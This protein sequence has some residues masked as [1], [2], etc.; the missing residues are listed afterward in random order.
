MKQ[1]TI[2]IA[3]LISKLFEAKLNRFSPKSTLVDRRIQST[4]VLC[5]I[6]LLLGTTLNGQGFV[7][8]WETS[9]AN[10]T[11]TIPTN[12]NESNYLYTVNWGDASTDNTSYTADASHQ[13]SSPGVYTVE[14]TGVFPAV[15]FNNNADKDKILTI[16]QWGNINWTTMERAFYGC[17]KVVSNATDA[18]NLTGVTNTSWMFLNATIFDG[19][20][21]GWDV[22]SV[23]DMSWM[24]NNAKAFNGDIS[25]WDVSSVTT[26]FLMLGGASSFNQDIGAWDV[27]NVID[28]TS[29]LFGTTS[30]NQ[31]ISAWDVSNVTSMYYLFRGA[32]VFN[33]DISS[34]DVSNVTNMNSMFFGAVEF[35]QDLSSWNVGQVEIMTDMF[36]NAFVFDQDLGGWDVTSVTDMARMLD[37]SGISQ[38]NYDATLIG[39]AS[40]TAL[41][42]AVSLGADGLIY[43]EAIT[44]R[45]TLTN[46]KG[47]VITG[48]EECL[49]EGFISTWQTT[50][51]NESITIPINAAYAN[52]AYTVDWGDGNLDNTVYTTDATHTYTNA[53][54]Y[55]V[56]ITGAFPAIQ[57][58][59]SGDRTKIVAIE[60]WG[61]T[62][63]ES[64]ENAFYG[65]SNLVLNATDVP[66][67]TN[68][69][70][71]TN[72]FNGATNFNGDLNDWDVSNVTSMV[73]TFQDA[74]SFNGN[75]SDWDVSSTVLML[76]TFNGASTFNQDLSGWDISNVVR[77]ENMF[78][79]ATVFNADLSGWDTS[80]IFDMSGMFTNAAAFDQDV[81]GWDV[82]SVT[83]MSQLFAGATVFNQD[84]GGWNVSAVTNM[85]SLFTSALA[86]NQD[87]GNWDVAAVTNMNGM[88]WNT[89]FNQDLSA[90]DVSSVTLMSQMFG[91]AT[92]FNQNL[93]AWDISSVNNMTTMLD[94][95]ALSTA[96]YDA[97][98][99][100]WAN[101]SGLQS[102]V[103]LGAN[104]LTYCTS[105][106]D[107]TDLISNLGWTI[108][109]DASANCSMISVLDFEQ[110]E[111][112]DG[113]SSALSYGATP[114]GVAVE[115]AFTIQNSG[116]TTLTISEVA[117]DGEGFSL[118]SE[119][120]TIV[121]GQSTSVFTITMVSE[122]EG[123]YEASVTVTSDNA[124]IPAYDF[125]ISGEV[126][127]VLGAE[128]LAEV[129]VYPNPASDF[130]HLSSD[131]MEKI[132][133]VSIR[134]VSGKE[135]FS[136]KNLTRRE[137]I[138]IPLKDFKPG[139]YYLL[140]QSKGKTNEYPFIKE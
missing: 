1:L 24:F 118:S 41:Q 22:S 85:N 15:Y 34:W 68:V 67:L 44:A 3:Q 125:T 120:P 69:T 46:A 32:S 36:R 33:V 4:F 83:D 122:E 57:F 138:S 140:L 70:S 9:E 66:D 65:C 80:N 121:E 103:T 93:G 39:W 76:S 135:F 114:E 77:T 96:N 91:N 102:N 112:S 38:T 78:R 74:I 56:D 40:L 124:D 132:Y 31:D 48:D 73:G 79:G 18:P 104:G 71:L 61:N 107:R 72:T 63:W 100:G 29:M 16:E 119:I 106:A 115:R 6:S 92:T 58:D 11:I 84:V 62:M 52:Y 14:V 20:L 12:P 97:T 136:I 94:N 28:M 53:G 54:T 117:V 59:N 110:R 108:S 129:S 50:A 95:T 137:K 139:I 131:N 7:T 90:W 86:F 111:I 13:Y 8:T 127:K 26:M 2:K 88:L 123:L 60:Q 10:E 23:T 116:F 89:P 25:T 37:Q 109:G 49:I 45:N 17:S 42:S 87:I 134:G 35:N 113:Q 128:E 30:F 126:V 43:C 51:S 99:T 98:L 133:A 47:W 105:N 82:S 130:L 75:V 5:A 55:T 21:S 64:M 101:I 19:D 27:S 81:S